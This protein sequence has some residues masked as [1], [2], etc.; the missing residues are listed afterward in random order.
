MPY[1]PPME[2]MQR[3]AS[4][5]SPPGQLEG[6]GEDAYDES[7]APAKDEGE[8]GGGET[9]E[10]PIALLGGKDFK[11]GEEIVFKIVSLDPQSG[12]AKIA[13]ATGDDEHD[14][15]EEHPTVAAMPGGDDGKGY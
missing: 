7:A 15:G 13:Y 2:R 1:Q 6:A 3:G 14:M 11:P 4:S 12:M 9:A 5:G 8:A 10:I